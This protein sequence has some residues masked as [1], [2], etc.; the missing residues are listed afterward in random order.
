MMPRPASTPGQLPCCG[1]GFDEISRD[2]LSLLMKVTVWP[3]ATVTDAGL[4]PLAVIVTVAPLAPPVPPSRTTTATP[5]PPGL[6]PLP[7]PPHADS[8]ASAAS[9]KRNP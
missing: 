8:T 5:P 4:T 1:C 9:E 7:P 3:T 6:L 2:R